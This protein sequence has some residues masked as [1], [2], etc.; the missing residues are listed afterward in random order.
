MIVAVVGIAKLMFCVFPPM[1][2]R[3]FIWASKASC[4]FDKAAR[5]ARV[6]VVV[7]GV[8]PASSSKFGNE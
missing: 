6:R 3:M 4:V 1:A 7:G 8:N 5:P 2:E